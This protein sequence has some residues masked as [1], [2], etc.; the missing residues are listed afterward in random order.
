MNKREALEF[1]ENNRDQ[2]NLL[3]D[4]L[5]K[6]E[7]VKTDSPFTAEQRKLMIELMEEWIM[8]VWTIS[9]EDFNLY[10]DGDNI[11]RRLENEDVETS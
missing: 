4:K 10:S 6:F 11:I 5:K 9:R 8:E 3:A 1:F 2:L 7:S